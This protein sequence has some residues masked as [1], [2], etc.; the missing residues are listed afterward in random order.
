M[1]IFRAN[2]RL[3]FIGLLVVLCLSLNGCA[4]IRIPFDIL[5][6]VLKI[7]SKLPKPPPGVFF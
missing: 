1:K 6:Q 3:V 2:N 7:V 5:G 4:L